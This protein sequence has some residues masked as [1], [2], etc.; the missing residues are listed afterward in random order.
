MFLYYYET[1]SFLLVGL[2][3]FTLKPSF[4]PKIGVDWNIID[5]REIMQFENLKVIIFSM[6]QGVKCKLGDGMG[7]NKIINLL[8][9][10]KYI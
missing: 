2:I 5:N 10:R 4:S 3:F 6:L 1:F 8:I 9:M 7:Y